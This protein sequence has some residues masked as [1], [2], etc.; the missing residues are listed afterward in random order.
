MG[1][2]RSKSGKR[3]VMAER[4]VGPCPFQ[5]VSKTAS[6]L[7]TCKVRRKNLQCLPI[8]RA[9]AVVV[10]HFFVAQLTIFWLRSLLV[11]PQHLP[12]AAQ[13]IIEPNTALSLRNG[14]FSH[15]IV[16]PFII[17]TDFYVN[18]LQICS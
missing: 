12:L 17:K 11:L 7:A 10:L 14:L 2:F 4:V 5:A 6:R 8:S 18:S 16:Y 13:F 1:G 3:K 15:T 9:S